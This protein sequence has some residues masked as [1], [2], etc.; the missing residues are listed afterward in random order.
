MTEA[1]EQETQFSWA[2]GDDYDCETCGFTYNEADLDLDWDESGVWMF[3]YRAG[4]YGGE[5]VMGSDPQAAQRLEA[6]LID[7]RAFSEWTKEHEHKVRSLLGV[8]R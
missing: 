7:L 6:I 8:Q 3:S 2:L 5:S 1:H 4:C